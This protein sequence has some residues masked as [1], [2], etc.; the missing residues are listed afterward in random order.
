MLFSRQKS[1]GNLFSGERASKQALYE[2][3]DN[4]GRQSEL[5]YMV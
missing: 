2:T 4:V 1:R 3:R 5:L